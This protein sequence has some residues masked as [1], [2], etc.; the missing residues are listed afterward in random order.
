MAKLNIN[1]AEFENLAADT[2]GG[3]LPQGEYQMQIIKSDIRETK[4]GNGWYLWL[5]FDVMGPRNVG[6]KHWE[7]LNLENPNEQA[8]KIANQNLLAISKGAGFSFPPEDSEQLHFK[9]MKVVI[10]HKD[11]KQGQL[12]ARASFYPLNAPTRTAPAAAEAPAAVAKPW[13]R[14]K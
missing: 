7:R 6:S 4:S 3:I 9:P 8:K 10:K 12:E 5:E 1:K 2:G 14:K 13:E 11:N